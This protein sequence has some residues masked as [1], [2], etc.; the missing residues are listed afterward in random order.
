VNAHKRIKLLPGIF[1]PPLL[2]IQMDGYI[3]EK[4]AA[5]ARELIWTRA[6][7]KRNHGECDMLHLFFCKRLH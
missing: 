5:R 4:E 3:S 1:H 7:S 2:A 6:E